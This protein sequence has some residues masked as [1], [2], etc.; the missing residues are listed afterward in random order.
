[1]ILGLN[2][3]YSEHKEESSERA[4]LGFGPLREEL[5]GV[6]SSYEDEAVPDSLR[7]TNSKEK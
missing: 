1:M 3:P 2:K 4:L 5:N 7:I 6:C